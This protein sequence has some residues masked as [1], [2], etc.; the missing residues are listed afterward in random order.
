MILAIRFN[1]PLRSTVHGV[2]PC[3]DFLAFFAKC[4]HVSLIIVI[5]DYCNSWTL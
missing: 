3:P 4:H 2:L 5:I 1:S